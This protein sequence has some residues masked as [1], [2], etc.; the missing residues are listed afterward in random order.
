MTT[1]VSWFRCRRRAWWQRKECL[2]PL[3]ASRH[4]RRDVDPLREV[5]VRCVCLSFSKR[6]KQ[7]RQRERIQHDRTEF[8]SRPSILY[9]L[10]NYF[11]VFYVHFSFTTTST[12]FC[13]SFLHVV[14]FFFSFFEGDNFIFLS[15]L[16]CL[17]WG[18]RSAGCVFLAAAAIISAASSF[19][20]TW[21]SFRVQAKHTGS[22][23]PDF[24]ISVGRAA[25]AGDRQ[26]SFR[27]PFSPPPNL[28]IPYFLVS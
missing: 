17:K 19:H 25:T 7:K 10:H 8:K 27:T 11:D 26:P 1:V 6:S 14:I 15:V 16:F 2:S 18:V 24:L 20:A 28:H 21:S 12:D 4:L 23:D 5:K 13:S 22:R 3:R 9:V